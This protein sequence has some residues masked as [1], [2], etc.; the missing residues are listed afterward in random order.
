MTFLVWVESKHLLE[1]LSGHPTGRRRDGDPARSKREGA[2]YCEA[3][4]YGRRECDSG[5]A[6]DSF[7]DGESEIGETKT[8]VLR[9][10]RPVTR[11][12]ERLGDL[13]IAWSGREE[14]LR[15]RTSRR[16]DLYATPPGQAQREPM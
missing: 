3:D 12:G 5:T 8:E 4:A 6:P 15:H 13:R 2:S 9:Q 14:G 7:G 16:C 11:R 10:W 1:E